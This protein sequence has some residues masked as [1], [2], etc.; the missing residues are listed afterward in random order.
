MRR[1]LG[2][3]IIAERMFPSFGSMIVVAF[4]W[5]SVVLGPSPSASIELEW[6]APHECPQETQLRERVEQLLGAPVDATSGEHFAAHGVVRHDG[7]RWDLDLSLSTA[8]GTER[9]PL[10]ADSCEALMEAAAVVI[11][12]ALA[13]RSRDEPPADDPPT[14]GTT[15]P[16]PAAPPRAETQKASPPSSKSPRARTELRSRSRPRSARAPRAPTLAV[17]PITG[18]IRAIGGFSAGPLPAIAPAVGLGLGLRRKALRAELLA[19]YFFARTAER[20]DLSARIAAWT[21]SAQFCFAPAW[22]RLEFPLCAG[23]ELGMMMGRGDNV[24]APRA[25]SLL[26]AAA[27]INAGLIVRPI[28]RIGIG[29]QADLVVPFTYPGF[30]VDGVGL[31]HRSSA[32]GAYG[33]MGLEV[34]FP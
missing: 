23:P 26:W 1:C 19:R 6:E 2:T 33:L 29:I 17:T 32:I 9:R 10:Q 15:P 12:I 16:T 21:V 30:S 13:P 31:L 24:D 28:P 22:R 7:T 25:E 34:R 11:S 5:T 27:D 14:A 18:F 20:E 4:G 8:D 3:L